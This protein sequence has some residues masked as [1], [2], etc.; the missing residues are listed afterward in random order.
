[1]ATPTGEKED[2]KV[3]IGNLSF[4]TDDNGL[5]Q[6]FESVGK[7]I[8]A[9]V[10]KRGKHRSAGYGFVTFETEKEA[11]QAV[12]KLD[13]TMLDDREITIQMASPKTEKTKRRSLP[14]RRPTTAST[15]RLFVANLPFVTTDEEMAALFADFSIESATVARLRNG[16][17]KGYG[18]V[19]V[20]NETEQQKIIDNF[21]PLMVAEREVTVKVAMVPVDVD[22]AADQVKQD[23]E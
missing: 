22:A 6:Y 15:T 19:D 5:K 8:D 2:N 1:M 9:T 12:E 4:S 23:E 7:V 17:S 14:A 13:K 16:R 18:F 11:Q 20:A 21:K 3:F 10:I